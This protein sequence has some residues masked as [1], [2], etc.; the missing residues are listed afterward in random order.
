MR[1][2]V[3][4]VERLPSGGERLVD[5]CIVDS[6]SKAAAL[7]TARAVCRRTSPARVVPI[8]AHIALDP[9][10]LGRSIP[11][12]QFDVLYRRI[13]QQLAGFRRSGR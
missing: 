11:T 6:D 5:V 13:E 8:P 7:A 3:S 2:W 4:F 10:D 12:D 1:Y 9:G